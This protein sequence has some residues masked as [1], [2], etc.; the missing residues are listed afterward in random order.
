MRT[1]ISC[2]FLAVCEVATFLV[3]LGLIPFLWLRML[4]W[5]CGGPISVS[6]RPQSH[7]AAEQSPQQFL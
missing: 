2:R 7:V 6:P 1:Q 3:G 4:F 5:G